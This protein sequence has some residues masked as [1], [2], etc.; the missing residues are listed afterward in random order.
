M[1]LSNVLII[2]AS[3]FL[4]KYVYNA[5]VEK[6]YNV[7][8]LGRT[9][10]SEKHHITADIKDSSI[11]L[12]N[13]DFCHVVHISGKAH[14]YP[15]TEDECVEFMQVNFDGTNN[16][17]NALDTNSIKPNYYTFIST[18]AVYGLEI[19]SAI[20]EQYEPHPITVYGESKL[21]AEKA[22]EEWGK[23]T[24]IPY[25]ILRLPLVVG[26]NAPGNLGNMKTAV[27]KGQYPK[28]KRNNAKKSMVLAEDVANLIVD[29]NG[30]ACGVYNITDGYHP[31]FNEVEQAM[32]KRT[33]KKI[34]FKLPFWSIKILAI[35]GNLL[36][37]V[38]KKDMPISSSKLEKLTSTL[39]FDD[40]KAKIEL[41]W[42]PNPVLPFIEKEL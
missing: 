17:L 31:S 27:S 11:K 14:V 41:G 26:A 36:E 28:I 19:G 34:L 32:E 12:P 9:K 42:N 25:L 20:S 29:Y 16:I 7:Y 15:K 22:I 2:G 5:F 3:G 39:T 35:I 10:I 24:S 4:G 37:G 6:G 30:E 1:K 13:I 18:V 8:T 40:S 38:L 33:G 23:R 21:K